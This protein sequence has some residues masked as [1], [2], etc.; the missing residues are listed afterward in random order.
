MVDRR[1]RAEDTCAVATVS[2]IVFL[3]LF[4]FIQLIFNYRMSHREADPLN[5]ST[6]TTSYPGGKH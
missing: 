1:S 3:L 5:Q 4:P 6:W 2:F